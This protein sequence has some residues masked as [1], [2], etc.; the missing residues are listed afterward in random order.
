MGRRVAG[1]ERLH[2]GL[3]DVVGRPLVGPGCQR[4]GRGLIPRERRAVRDGRRPPAG[5]PGGGLRPALDAEPDRRQRTGQPSQAPPRRPPP[6]RR[7][8]G[9][10]CRAAQQ[11]FGAVV[12]LGRPADRHE[13]EL[14]ADAGRNVMGSGHGFLGVG[15]QPEPSVRRAARQRRCQTPAAPA[16]SGQRGGGR[17]L[18]MFRGRPAGRHPAGR[19]RRPGA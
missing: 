15:G 5:G 16:T 8:D 12:P 10:D 11:Q 4:R 18:L 17:R 13:Q 6:D 19:L 3:V 2:A 9:G 1:R 7:G 14:I